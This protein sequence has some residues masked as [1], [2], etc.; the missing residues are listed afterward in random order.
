MKI[1]LQEMLN[2][3]FFKKK[4]KKKRVREE[5]IALYLPSPIILPQLPYH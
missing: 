2:P 3:I 1:D 4:K 5:N